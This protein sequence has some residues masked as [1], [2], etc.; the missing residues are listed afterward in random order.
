MA[1]AYK[2]NFKGEGWS[3]YLRCVGPHGIGKAAMRS[4]LE[5]WLNHQ[6]PTRYYV[7]LLDYP[8]GTCKEI[9]FERVARLL[10]T[11]QALLEVS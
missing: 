9:R 11:G 5:S 3:K 7:A 6:P 10:A 2:L 4:G 8:D 1:K